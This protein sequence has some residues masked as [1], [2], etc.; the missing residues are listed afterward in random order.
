MIVIRYEVIIVYNYYLHP[1]WQG[2][3]CCRNVAGHL[4]TTTCG[5]ENSTL[6]FYGRP[7][8]GTIWHLGNVFNP[9]WLFHIHYIVTSIDFG[10]L[11]R[12]WSIDLFTL[13]QSHER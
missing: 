13:Q 1:D 12:G 2:S 8:E 11:P 9:S 10:I 4:A 5:T 3:D 6:L 7:Y